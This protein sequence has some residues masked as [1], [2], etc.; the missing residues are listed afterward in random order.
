MHN[1]ECIVKNELGRSSILHFAFY[2][3]HLESWSARQ[4]LHLRSLGPRP[5]V[6]AATL[7]AEKL[8]RRCLRRA[9]D[10]GFRGNKSPATLLAGVC[11]EIWRSRPD[12]HRHSSRRQRV[13]FLFSYGS[14]LKCRVKSVECRTDTNIPKPRG[15]MYSALC[16]L[17]FSF[18]WGEVL[19][20]LQSS[21]PTLFA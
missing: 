12:L 15:P 14:D 10:L 8:P 17:H 13:A 3:L 18:K 21:L 7:R 20:M 1:E 9:G 19:V 5:S 6:L 2:T 11:C 4:D 16:I